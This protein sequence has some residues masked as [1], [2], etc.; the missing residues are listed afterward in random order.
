MTA[1]LFGRIW[2]WLRSQDI[3]AVLTSPR[4]TH[5]PAYMAWSPCYIIGV[6]AV[7]SQGCSS[8]STSFAEVPCD[9]TSA[10]QY[11]AIFKPCRHFTYNAKYWN[12]DFDLLSESL[13]R[14]TITGNPASTNRKDEMEI[15]IQYDFDE[16]A[17]PQVDKYNLNN[18]FKGREWLRQ[19]TSVGLD[20]G[21]DTWITPFRENQFAFTQ[22]APFP[23]VN[24]PLELNK[25]WTSN[26]LIY[27][28]WGDWNN[29]QLL[30]HYLVLGL[31][32]ITYQNESIQAWHVTS[33]VDTDF[34]T[35][36]HDFWYNETLGFVKMQYKNYQ[37]QLLIFKL[38]NT[39]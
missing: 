21:L 27:E 36:T 7:L 30:S 6:L 28:T 22:V 1:L 39:D 18:E 20:N 34:G 4:S 35:S 5:H 19:V 9:A 14:M 12:E 17:I 31:E 32:E 8:S 2:S 25:Q 29:Q 24:L 15:V 13:V 38:L 37:G 26:L 33:Y 10:Y 11:N 3:R 23:S 16:D